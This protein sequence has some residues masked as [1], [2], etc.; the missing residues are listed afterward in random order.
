LQKVGPFPALYCGIDRDAL[1]TVARQHQRWTQ[2]QLAKSSSV[3]GARLRD[4]EYPT[5]RLTEDWE[6]RVPPPG[7]R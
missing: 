3:P 1:V 5:I 7:E 4:A 6:S 2:D